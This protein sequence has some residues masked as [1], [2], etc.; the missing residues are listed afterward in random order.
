MINS[1]SINHSINKIIQILYSLL[2]KI[3]AI[4]KNMCEIKNNNLIKILRL[5]NNIILIK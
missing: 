3:L 2:F 1:F 4:N 5:I